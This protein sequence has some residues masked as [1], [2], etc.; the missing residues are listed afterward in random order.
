MRNSWQIHEKEIQK[1]IYV[2]KATEK[3]VKKK[4]EYEM[5]IWRWKWNRGE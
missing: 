2:Q 4:I 5:S 3:S 1:K